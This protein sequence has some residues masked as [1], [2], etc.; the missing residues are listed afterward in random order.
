[1][2]LPGGPVPILSILSPEFCTNQEAERR[3]ASLLLRRLDIERDSLSL[4]EWG[5]E[6]IFVKA[7]LLG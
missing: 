1:M 5:P 6:G 7:A 3:A 4:Y 2:R